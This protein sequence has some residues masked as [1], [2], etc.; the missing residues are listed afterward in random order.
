M[1]VFDWV[2]ETESKNRVREL[3]IFHAYI[4]INKI[5]ILSYTTSVSTKR[6]I[7]ENRHIVF[8]IYKKKGQENNGVVSC[9][10]LNIENTRCLFLE[11]VL[12]NLHYRIQLITFE[13]EGLQFLRYMTIC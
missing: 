12:F 13:H 11:F 8:W 7:S 2:V 6:T 4:Y 10:F 5:I 3:D 1:E 9:F